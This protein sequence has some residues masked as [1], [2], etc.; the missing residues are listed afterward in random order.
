[1][2]FYI[3]FWKKI[4]PI[5][6]GCIAFF[7]NSFGS[8]KTWTGGG[9]DG[10][11]SNSANWNGGLVPLPADDVILDNS[12]VLSDYTVV[13]PNTGVIVKSIIIGPLTGRIIQLILPSSNL[14][15]PALTATGPGYGLIINSGGIFQNASG[16]TSGESL[17]IADS[18]RINNGGRYIHHTRASHAN[19][20]ARL[21]S[22]APGTENGVFEFDVPRASYTVSVSNRIYGTI[23]FNSVAAGGAINYTC[24][25]SNPL[26]VNG[27]LQIN[28][29]VNLSVDLA[30]ANG[31]IVVKGDY[32]QQGGVFN[33]ASGAGN[34][35]VLRIAGNLL[36]SSTGQ[37]TET[38]TG[39]PFIEL[40]GS[41][42]QLI[43]LA[44]T[45]I[46]NVGFRMNN[47]AG[48]SLLSP[49]KLPYKLQLVN[50]KIT[51]SSANLL[52]L[53]TGCTLIADSSNSAISFIDG[54]LRK[55]GLSSLGSFLFPVGKNNSMRWLE[56]KNVSGNFTIE[57][58]N[59]NPMLLNN[60]YGVGIAH[61]S[62]IEY[63]IVSA[64]AGPIATGNVELSF[65]VPESG[66]ITDLSFLNVASLSSGLWEDVGHAGTT[67]TFNTAGSVISNTI[68]NFPTVSYFTL[69]STA[70]LQ[71]PLPISLIDFKGQMLNNEA[72]F[73]WQIDLPGDI[74]YFE[75]MK[76]INSEFKVVAKVPGMMTQERYS[77]SYDSIENGINYFRLRA[78]DRNG[79]SNFSK[80]IAVNNYKSD[81]TVMIAPTVIIGNDLMIH[82][83]IPGNERLEW[84]VTSM[85]GKIVKRGFLNVGTGSNTILIPLPNLARGMYQI[86][87]VNNKRQFCS[88]RFIKQ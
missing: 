80:I 22:S 83:N 68:N 71:N 6:I 56:L 16:L 57:Y 34:S 14:V 86:V 88:V 50:G 21:L 36:Q 10:Q 67:G 82:V 4:F 65:A 1:M 60:S 39:L 40:N 19:N 23:V 59:E 41:T 42:L 84:I 51:S 49:L 26:T 64:D 27:N 74:E 78:T 38:N 25:G 33:L 77:L 13:F 85:E 44:G 58:M 55:E 53:Q 8:I 7:Q 43:S 11:W 5:L 24:T 17:N 28:N 9:G 3:W 48:A 35:T 30:S 61:I 76:K 15:E 32:I 2:N 66:G 20:I 75:L 52:T 54:P 47:A 70:D 29:G 87:V 31:N 79:N 69:A 63:W 73:S 46:N 81:F 37:I 45:I 72:M 18:V 12:I 62:N